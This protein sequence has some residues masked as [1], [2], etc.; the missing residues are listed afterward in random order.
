M[1]DFHAAGEALRHA[2]G[3]TWRSLLRPTRT[4]PCITSRSARLRARLLLSTLVIAYGL[5]GFVPPGDCFGCGEQSLIG[6][7][8]KRAVLV[9]TTSVA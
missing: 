9:A 7:R 1:I 3:A 5:L 6:A 4:K 2:A 8:N